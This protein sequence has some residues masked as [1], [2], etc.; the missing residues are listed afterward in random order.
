MATKKSKPV[1]LA[2]VDPVV[3]A[4]YK[5]VFSTFDRDGD[6]TIDASELGAVM[7]SF[8]VNPSV[9]ELEKMIQDVDLDQSG[10]IDFAE[11]VTMMQG[12]SNTSNPE[13]EAESVFYIMDKDKDGLISFEDLA[14]A[15]GSVGWG[16]EPRP[17]EGDIRNMLKVKGALS[18][19]STS[20]GIDLA[21]FKKIVFGK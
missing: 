7:A 15:V 13:D 20:N 2:S 6:G 5:E 9:A 3:L 18:S 1:D 16:N 17:N 10:A 14:L 19:S 4:E 11:F 21:T 12:R 8:G